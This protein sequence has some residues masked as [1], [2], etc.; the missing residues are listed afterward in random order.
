MVALEKKFICINCGH[1]TDELYTKYSAN[2]M[3]IANCE[4][5]HQIADKY[6]EFEPIVIVIDLVLLS[7]PTYRHVLY[8]TDFRIHWKLSLIICLLDAYI[9]WSNK[10][11]YLASEVNDEHFTKEKFFYLCFGLAV[12]DNLV[13]MALLSLSLRKS[14]LFWSA[15]N[16]L[17]LLIKAMCLANV[18]KFFLLPIVIWKTQQSDFVVQLNF[19]LFLGYFISSLINAHSVISGFGRIYSGFSVI[20][21]LAIKSI[22]FNVFIRYLE[23]NFFLL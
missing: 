8:N 23:R 17:M 19:M 12:T 15:A 11:H 9:S 20:S 5:C 10:F 6:I 18:A 7:R 21:S 16:P 4:K 3:K 2:V 13:L 1:P 14:L 22:M